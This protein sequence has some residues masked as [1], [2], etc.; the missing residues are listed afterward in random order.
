MINYVHIFKQQQTNKTTITNEQ[1]NLLFKHDGFLAFSEVSQADGVKQSVAGTGSSG[2]FHKVLVDNDYSV[3][4]VVI[5]QL[6]E[7]T[8]A[9]LTSNAT[10]LDKTDEQAEGKIK[11][12]DYYMYNQNMY[13]VFNNKLKDTH[14]CLGY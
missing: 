7:V 5:P 12:K 11:C 14:L 9:K 6:E 1:I 2:Q 4:E 3:P 13:L 8:S 10:T